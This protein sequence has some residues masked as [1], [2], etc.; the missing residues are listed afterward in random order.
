MA[1][2]CLLRTLMHVCAPWGVSW[3]HSQETIG[4]ILYRTLAQFVK[5]F[6]NFVEEDLG[7]RWGYLYN[8]FLRPFIALTEKTFQSNHYIDAFIYKNSYFSPPW[9]SGEVGVGSFT[10][11]RHRPLYPTIINTIDDCWCLLF[12]HVGYSPRTTVQGIPYLRTHVGLI[13]GLE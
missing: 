1:C 12:L 13:Q 5:N 3:V 7:V 6:Q 9:N 2:V 8:I 10:R 11:S 4:R